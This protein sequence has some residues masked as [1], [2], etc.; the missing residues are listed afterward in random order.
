MSGE[1]SSGS[2]SLVGTRPASEA[3]RRDLG[4]SLAA[5]G[6]E[7]SCLPDDDEVLLVLEVTFPDLMSLTGVPEVFGPV[8]PLL[9]IA[10]S[11]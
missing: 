3:S 7:F 5:N 9:S 4:S 11:L 2:A 8:I 6:K 1:S 10:I